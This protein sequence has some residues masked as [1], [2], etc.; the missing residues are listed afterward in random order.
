MATAPDKG[1][2]KAAPPTRRLATRNPWHVQVVQG[3]SS[4]SQPSVMAIFGATS[5]RYLFHAP[6]GTSRACVQSRIALG[7]KRL[8]HVFLPGVETDCSGGLFGT[9]LGASDQKASGEMKVV[10][11]RGTEHLLASARL[12]TKRDNIGVKVEEVSTE[13]DGWQRVLEDENL[14]VYALPTLPERQTSDGRAEDRSPLLLKRK[15]GSRSPSPLPRKRP[16][17]V[18]ATSTSASPQMNGS[19]SRESPS[20]PSRLRGAEAETWRQ[21]VIAD[22]FGLSH[23]DPPLPPDSPLRGSSYSRQRLPSPWDEAS[24]SRRRVAISYLAIGPPQRG[25]FLPQ[26]AKAFGVKPGPD[27]ALLANGERL[28]VSS[29]T[30]DGHTEKRWVEPEECMEEAEQPSVRLPAMHPFSS[31]PTGRPRL[32]YISSFV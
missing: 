5:R 16:H 2:G 23:L 19:T 11:P 32:R 28:Q 27:F 22:M 18:A 1:K 7:I 6:E 20:D 21:S 8:G 12:F 15:L 14:A 17:T 4:D 30:E 25:R 24:S 13:Q 10:G 31:P 3:A 26:K 9:I 29:K